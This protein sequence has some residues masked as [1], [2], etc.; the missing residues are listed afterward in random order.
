[1]TRRNF[2]QATAQVAAGMVSIVLG[3]KT[4]AKPVPAKSDPVHVPNAVSNH[5][6]RLMADR[7]DLRAC[8]YQAKYEIWTKHRKL[9]NVIYIPFH[10]RMR[11]EAEVGSKL[12]EPNS[13]RINNN[14]G[15]VL[16]GLQVCW[17]HPANDRIY[18]EYVKPRKGDLLPR[19]KKLSEVFDFDRLSRLV[20]LAW[21]PPSFPFQGKT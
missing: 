17:V 16:W 20:P 12:R 6:S 19:F 8:I 5:V 3:V 1:M 2:L 13:A 18:V 21:R 11:V 15:N 10:W 4:N 9:A 7:Y 14:Q